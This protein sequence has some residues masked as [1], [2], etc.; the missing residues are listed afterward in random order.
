MFTK[1][2]IRRLFAREYENVASDALQPFGTAAKSMGSTIKWV[3]SVAHIDGATSRD[4]IECLFDKNGSSQCFLGD[5]AASTL[6]IA[7]VDSRNIP[8]WAPVFL[9]RL[10]ECPNITSVIVRD[11]SWFCIYPS[12]LYF[13]NVHVTALT[14]ESIKFNYN[15]ELM[16]SAL[17]HT[18]P[19]L[20][21]LTIGTCDQL[22]IT[23]S[24]RG[25]FHNAC[26]GSP[27]WTPEYVVTRMNMTHF[28]LTD[29]HV[30]D[31]SVISELTRCLPN[32]RS[33][34]LIR[35]LTCHN[36]CL[37]NRN[38]YPSYGLWGLFALQKLEYLRLDMLQYTLSDLEALVGVMKR[39]APEYINPDLHWYA[40]LLSIN[41]LDEKI[42]RCTEKNSAELTDTIEQIIPVYAQHRK[43]ACSHTSMRRIRLV[44][45]KHGV[46]LLKEQATLCLSEFRK[47]Y[48]TLAY[49]EEFERLHKVLA[50]LEIL[51]DVSYE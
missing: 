29:C 22:G 30:L 39:N 20:T 17:F 21:S 13:R 6:C 10:F 19:N 47:Q 41:P 26:M 27:H 35:C 38:K 49:H 9:M 46:P 31:E 11:C 23:A 36:A 51:Y 28:A 3:D 4:D 12:I 50:V 8:T 45:N 18:F 33:L 24:V 40:Q 5:S 16:L 32:L 7:S 42:Y 2:R 44:L 15:P 37:S 14:L 34:A 48:A 43:E 1:P 25:F